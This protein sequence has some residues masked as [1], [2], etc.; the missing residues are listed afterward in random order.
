MTSI[1]A[2]TGTSSVI[3]IG[4][5]SH[6]ASASCSKHMTVTIASYH[7]VAIEKAEQASATVT[8]DT[9]HHHSDTYLESC[10][11]CLLSLS[12]FVEFQS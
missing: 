12:Y 4:P 6:S 8:A 9:T 7:F 2:R 3:H 5:R 11:G 1:A 10:E